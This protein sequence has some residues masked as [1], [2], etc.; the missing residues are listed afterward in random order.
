M[1]D[2]KTTAPAEIKGVP[3][4]GKPDLIKGV[5][6]TRINQGGVSAPCALYDGEVPKKDERITFKLDNGVTY[7]GIVADATEADGTVLVEFKDGI[8]P[9]FK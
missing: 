2:D 6:L 9:V 1:A 4:K 8:A 3:K 7:T 5:T